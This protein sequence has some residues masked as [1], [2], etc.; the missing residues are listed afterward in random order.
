MQLEPGDDG[1]ILQQND[2][3]SFRAWRRTGRP[4]CH[5]RP[6]LLLD[7]PLSNLDLKRREQM[8]KPGVV[9]TGCE[10]VMLRDNLRAFGQR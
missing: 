4:L 5:L 6:A 1:I 7:E 10:Y 2:Y 8:R 3:A 9:R